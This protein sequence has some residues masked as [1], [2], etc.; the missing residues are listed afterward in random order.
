MYTCINGEY[1]WLEMEAGHKPIE[2]IEIAFVAQFSFSFGFS[3]IS[4]TELQNIKID[5]L[6]DFAMWFRL[7][8]SV[9]FAS[10]R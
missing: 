4:G 5:S 7:L 9:R 8:C 1:Y 2:C 3:N 6:V 10:V